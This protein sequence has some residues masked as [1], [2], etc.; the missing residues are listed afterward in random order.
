MPRIPRML[1]F[2]LFILSVLPLQAQNVVKRI[3]ENGEIRIGTTAQQPPFSVKSK[4]GNV[5]GF[6]I[7]IALKLAEAIHVEAN[8]IEMNFSELLEALDRGEIDMVVS[9]ITI[10]PERNLKYLFAGPYLLSGKSILTKNR[11]LIQTP[12]SELNTGRIS[13]AT[14]KGSTSVTYVQKYLAA[15]DLTLVD[16]YEDAVNMVIEGKIDMMLADYSECAYASFRHQNHGLLIKE[17]LFSSERI[18]IAI[19]ASDPL[20][21]NLVNNFI[22]DLDDSGELKKIEDRWFRNGSWLSEVE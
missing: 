2:S 18:G 3:V 6:D 17:E 12:I 9:G 7:D 5:I 11:K 16:S 8:F 4:A 14:L 22:S 19:P 21:L 15:T 20:L 1:I 10:T 13:V